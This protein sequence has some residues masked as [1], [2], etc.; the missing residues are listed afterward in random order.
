M[1]KNSERLSR[2]VGLPPSAI[3]QPR[4]PSSTGRLLMV[5]EPFGEYFPSF[6]WGR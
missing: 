4:A 5:G 3:R 1:V 6:Y 2:E